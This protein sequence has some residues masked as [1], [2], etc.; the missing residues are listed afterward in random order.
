MFKTIKTQG[1]VRQQQN[2]KYMCNWRP[3]RRMRWKTLFHKIIAK[4]IQNLAQGVHLQM[5]KLNEPKQDMITRKST[6]GIRYLN[7]GKPTLGKTLI[8]DTMQGK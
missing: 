5:Q 3:G 2:V 7:D 1:S 8:E 6:S 4:N